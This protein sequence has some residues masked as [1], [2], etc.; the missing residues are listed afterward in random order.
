[1][2]KNFIIALMLILVLPLTIQAQPKSQ[3]DDIVDA[4]LLE[5]FVAT[6]TVTRYPLWAE[7]GKKLTKQVMKKGCYCTFK[8]DGMKMIMMETVPVD[9]CIFMTGIQ[10]TE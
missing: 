9:V 4:E 7:E 1:M 5:C 6:Y 2:I 8:M 10:D 3:G